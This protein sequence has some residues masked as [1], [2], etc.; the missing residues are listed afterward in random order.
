MNRRIGV[1]VSTAIALLASA[2]GLS[3]CSSTSSSATTCTPATPAQAM[4][5]HGSLAVRTLRRD[6]ATI[7]NSAEKQV[8][9]IPAGN[10]GSN[11]ISPAVS[12]DLSLMATQLSVLKYPPQ[13][14]TA[15]NEMATQTRS[16]AAS[17][18]SGQANTASGNALLSA[19]N[20]SQYFYEALGIPSVCTTTTGS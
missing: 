13:Y 17:L 12:D 19:V 4:A 7:V 11:S 5:T 1:A 14:Q 6:V 10:G 3:A 15:A 16:L 9:T 20:A 2:L 8:D 18:Q